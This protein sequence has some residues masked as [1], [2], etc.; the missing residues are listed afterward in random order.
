MPLKQRHFFS[1]ISSVF[2]TRHSYVIFLHCDPHTLYFVFFAL[3]DIILHIQSLRIF[4]YLCPMAAYYHLYHTQRRRPLQAIYEAWSEATL[5]YPTEAAAAGKI[6]S[7]YRMYRCRQQYLHTVGCIVTMQRVYRG[8]LGRR[9]FLDLSIERALAMRQRVFDHYATTIQRIFRAF[10]SRKWKSDYYAQKRYLQHIMI[11]SEKVRDQAERDRMIQSHKL[12]KEKN[13]KIRKDFVMTANKC[14]HLLSTGAQAGIFRPMA[15]HFQSSKTIFNTD[16]EEELRHIPSEHR[17][18]PTILKR[19]LVQH[20]SKYPRKIYK[21]DVIPPAGGDQ[22]S[23]RNNTKSKKE[24]TSARKKR[25]FDR[26]SRSPTSSPLRE[27]SSANQRLPSVANHFSTTA[28]FS[29]TGPSLQNQ[30]PY[31]EAVERAKLERAVDEKLTTHVHGPA[32]QHVKKE[33][34]HITKS[35]SNPPAAA[36]FR[37]RSNQQNIPMK[38]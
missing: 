10:Y 13:D 15:Q 34:K 4:T 16:I 20:D 24:M 33:T 7:L 14:H 9:R 1:L 21:T 28:T 6:Q 26:Y 12:T 35:I 8:Y 36:S 38:R 18:G 29:S 37:S 11:E 25:E 3:F 27:N 19:Q 31:N 17:E 5:A 30:L 32:V 23:G 22:G 2:F